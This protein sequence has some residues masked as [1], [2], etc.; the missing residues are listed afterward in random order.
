MRTEHG[1][2]LMTGLLDGG[3]IPP[4]S[5]GLIVNWFEETEVETYRYQGGELVL[6]YQK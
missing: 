3:A 1:E 2:P 6:I 4:T 5:T